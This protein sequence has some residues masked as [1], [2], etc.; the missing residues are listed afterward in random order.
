[1]VAAIKVALFA[2]H[3]AAVPMSAGE[4]VRFAL[5]QPLLDLAYVGGLLRGLWALTRSGASPTIR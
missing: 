5:V 1:M 4:T 2:R 3:F